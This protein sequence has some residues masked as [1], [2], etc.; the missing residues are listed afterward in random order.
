MSFPSA[1]AEPTPSITRPSSAEQPCMEMFEEKQLMAVQSMLRQDL[2]EEK[3]RIARLCWKMHGRGIS[4]SQSAASMCNYSAKEAPNMN[5]VESEEVWQERCLLEEAA[6]AAL[7]TEIIRLR[8]ECASLR[9]KI[10]CSGQSKMF[11]STRF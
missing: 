11:V 6:R 10:E 7:T 1:V 8:N 3:R 2:L 4:C 5:V 9:A